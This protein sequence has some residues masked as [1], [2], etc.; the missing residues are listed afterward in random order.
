MEE[1]TG[2]RSSINFPVISIILGAFRV[3]WSKRSRLARAVAAPATAL[4]VIGMYWAY[5]GYLAGTY[6]SVLWVLLYALALTPFAVACHRVL[7]LGDESLPR[8]GIM[9]WTM[10]EGRYLAWLLAAWLLGFLAT[11]FLMMT[12]GTI[13]INVFNIPRAWMEVGWFLGSFQVLGTYVL[14]RL[15]LILPA[16]ALDGRPSLSRIW[17]LS[18]GNGWRLTVV[19]CGL[20][21]LLELSQGFIHLD[22]ATFVSMTLGSLVFCPLLVVEVAALSLSYKELVASA[23]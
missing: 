11:M 18:D 13:V 8:Y 22:E 6:G 17:R 14:A 19:V 21:W 5:S 12:I 16:I 10:R 2:K 4:I 7:L 1:E 9:K 3:P 20:P 15:S 23:T